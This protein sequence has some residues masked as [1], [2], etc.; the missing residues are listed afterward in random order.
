VTAQYW[1]LISGELMAAGPRWPEGMRVSPVPAM[2]GQLGTSWY[3]IEDDHAPESL[4][5][6]KVEL[7]FSQSAGRVKVTDRKALP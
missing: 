5:G 6:C 4:N 1:T 3:L 7:A 2:P